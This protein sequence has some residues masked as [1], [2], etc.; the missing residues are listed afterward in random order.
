MRTFLVSLLFVVCFITGHPR[1]GHAEPIAVRSVGVR[2]GVSTLPTDKFFHQY[3]AFTVVKLPWEL[4]SS[5]GFGVAT[6]LDA[7]AGVLLGEGRSGLIASAGPAVTLGKTGFPLEMDIGISAAGLSRDT[8]GNRDFDGNL[9]FISH[10][11]INFRFTRHVG[12]GYRLQ[13]MSNAGL[14]GSSNPGLNMHLLEL[15]WYFGR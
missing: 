1:H 13:H 4:R 7:T 12:C 5:S 2:G 14:N 10:V 15:D 8:F 3:E 11:G 6:L 9:Q